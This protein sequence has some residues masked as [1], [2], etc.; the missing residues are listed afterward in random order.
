MSDISTFRV[1]VDEALETIESAL[2]SDALNDEFGE[3]GQYLC[4]AWY[5]SE[6]YSPEFV[7][8]LESEI[9]EF[10]YQL[11]G[12]FRQLPTGEW[13]P[14]EFYEAPLSKESIE[15]AAAV[16][17]EALSRGKL[18]SLMTDTVCVLLSARNLPGTLPQ[19]LLELVD[20][21]LIDHR[22]LYQEACS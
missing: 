5:R 2:R 16:L 7:Q 19:E 18:P 8:A 3:A 10:Y 15:E 21:S 9:V 12:D 13:I 22:N 20:A 4:R 6:V 11:G 14:E 17:D 1:G